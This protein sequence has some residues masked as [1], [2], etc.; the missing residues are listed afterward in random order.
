MAKHDITVRLTEEQVDKFFQLT[1]K[2]IQIN[3]ETPKKPP[4]V[5]AQI[6]I[7]PFSGEIRA[8]LYTHEQAKKI[9]AVLEEIERC[10]ST[11]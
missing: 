8:K 1:Y 2:I 5:F 6:W 10:T 7:G 4:S 3:N 11:T 9:H